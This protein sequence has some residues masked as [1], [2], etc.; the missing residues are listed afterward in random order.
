V[1]FLVRFA[2]PA[3][4]RFSTS[5]V[6][7]GTALFTLYVPSFKGPWIT[8][9]PAIVKSVFGLR[10]SHVDYRLPPTVSE[11][12]V[13]EVPVHV[14]QSSGLERSMS[15]VVPNVPIKLQDEKVIANLILQ[16]LPAIMQTPANPPPQAAAIAVKPQPK[17]AGVSFALDVLQSEAE[18]VR[19]R[20]GAAA[21]EAF[22]FQRL[23][24][25]ARLATVQKQKESLRAIQQSYSTLN[26]AGDDRFLFRLFAN[27]AAAKLATL[28][29]APTVS[30]ESPRSGA[31]GTA[32][33]S[34]V[35][36]PVPPPLIEPVFDES[37]WTW[38]QKIAAV[39]YNLGNCR[40][41]L[42]ARS[43]KE[44]FDSASLRRL[45]GN[46]LVLEVAGSYTSRDGT[47][48]A[49]AARDGVIVGFL[50]RAWEGLVIIHD[51]RIQVVSS[52]EVTAGMLGGEK[53]K[54]LQIFTSPDDFVEFLDLIRKNKV[55]VIQ[56]HL[57]TLRGKY[58][59]TANDTQA[60]RRRVL[61]TRPG[62]DAGSVAVIDFADA[63]DLTL[64]Q[65][66]R[67]LS[68]FDRE[69]T[70]V[71]LDT[72]AWDFGRLYAADPNGRNVGIQTTSDEKL[73][74]KL[75]FIRNVRESQ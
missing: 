29:D 64:R 21:R 37:I 45:Y 65:C 19:R 36:R 5:P 63:R 34:G 31:W 4:Y 74:N 71:N 20:S 70:A 38:Q 11:R 60:A 30:P 10:I 59:T 61:M 16:R 46:R 3:P 18:A 50:P 39:S 41:A 17:E 6:A 27:F 32:E 53:H 24:E 1:T 75:V 25:F 35:T 67:W 12:E 15:I 22:L 48:A 49:L 14:R 54:R 72:G 43:G 8:M 58:D 9:D 55:S 56:G 51:G 66:A 68:G 28:K 26:A 7:S 13:V 62:T 47:I 57:L 42:H 73:S 69:G 23:E 44:P 33:W 52:L 2:R 40:A